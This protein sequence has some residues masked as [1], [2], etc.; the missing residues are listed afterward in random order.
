MPTIINI[1]IK[2][3]GATVPDRR[4]TVFE[5][6]IRQVDLNTEHTWWVEWF[7]ITINWTV[8]TRPNH[9]Y[10]KD[11]AMSDIEFS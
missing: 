1:R 11:R 10:D 9:F 3:G 4:C 5:N 6:S 8:S 7:Y 2:G